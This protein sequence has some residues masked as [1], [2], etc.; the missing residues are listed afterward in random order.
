MEESS[1]LVKDEKRKRKRVWRR[2]GSRGQVFNTAVACIMG[3]G[4]MDREGEVEGEGE[5]LG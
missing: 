4:G 2:K 1:D 5:G 3:E